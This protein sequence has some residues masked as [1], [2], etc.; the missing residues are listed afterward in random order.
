MARG[1]WA[2][3]PGSR[4]GLW[5]RHAGEGGVLTGPRTPTPGCAV[6]QR[7]YSAERRDRC[8]RTN[9]IRSSTMGWDTAASVAGVAGLALA[10]YTFV[11]DHLVGRHADVQAYGRTEPEQGRGARSYRL[12]LENR[13]P[14]HAL[15]LRVGLVDDLGNDVTGNDLH[16]FGGDPRVIATLWA[17]QR[18][19]LIVSIG[20][21]TTMH[22]A[23]VSWKDGRRKRQERDYRVSF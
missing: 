6:I 14:H 2:V 5:A 19:E 17:G 4:C 16:A 12:V 8:R 13:G 7:G 9:H 3:R 15:D 21:G 23:R 18:F 20:F 11:T 22:S 1:W 10:T